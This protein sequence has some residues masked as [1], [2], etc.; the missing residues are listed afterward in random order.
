MPAVS[1]VVA[2]EEKPLLQ[3]I[4]LLMR[5]FRHVLRLI[6]A[7]EAL[8]FL[9]LA[10]FVLRLSKLAATTSLR[11]H[12]GHHSI[13]E[14][15]SLM[16]LMAVLAAIAA[17]R[18]GRGDALGRW[19]LL[20][21]SIFNLLLFPVGI[22]VA[23]AG[24]FYFARNPPMDPR[25]NRK[26][27]QPIEGDGTSKW[28]GPIFMVAQL[29]WGVVV[30]NSI[31]GW[32]VARGM[33]QIHSDVLF[34]MTLA[35]AVY[36]CILFHELGH[37]VLGDIVRFRLI[38]FG[39]GP[40]SWT[41][42]TGRW[43]SQMRYDKLLGGHTAMVPTTPRNIRTRFM[44]LTLGGPLASA[45]LGTIGALS[46]LLIPGPA[47]P[48]ALGRTAA[49]ITGFALGDFLFNLLPMASEAQYSDGALLWQ[50]VRGGPWCD[51]HCA[52]HYMALSRTT[53]LRPRDWPTPMVERAAE[54]AAQ[55]QIRPD[56]S[57]WRTCIS[58][59]GAIGSALFC[60]WR[61]PI[62]QRSREAGW[63]TR[64]S[65]IAPI[66]KH[67]TVAIAG[68]HSA[69][70]R[71]RLSGTIRPITGAPLPLSGRPKATWRERPKPG[72]RQPRSPGGF[73]LPE[74]MTW[75]GNSFDSSAHGWQSFGHSRF[76]R[77][78]KN[79]ESRIQNPNSRIQN[80]EVRIQNEVLNAFF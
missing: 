27:H 35:G 34:W 62:R 39:V 21:V 73:R 68:K 76:R 77:K 57:P 55:L 16:V 14:L 22:V 63:L 42:A 65:Q 24:I 58:W 40:L 41:Y 61:R 47:W 25:F 59:I 8:G 43:R 52:N 50:M 37:L 13:A 49:L 10:F 60:G 78:T 7:L 54:F 19:S 72:T 28:S 53:P 2:L 9:S 79:S 29:V 6:F 36:G 17:W 12:L 5:A 80:P 33:P 23:A 45:T 66:A 31:R 74:C 20:A 3:P 70:S 71:R 56:R 11:L 1:Q 32:T 44:I 4:S 48:A 51:F 46:L 38:G 15:F 69:G 75:T 18:L 30:L 64:S 26:H 67:S